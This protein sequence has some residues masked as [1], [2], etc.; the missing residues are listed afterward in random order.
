MYCDKQIYAHHVLSKSL[1]CF[2]HDLNLL[3][4][5][6]Y[7]ERGN[8]ASQYPQFD[9]DFVI[10]CPQR[11]VFAFNRMDGSLAWQ[12][13]FEKP[14]GSFCVKN[15]VVYCEQQAHVVLLDASNGKV[16]L[17]WDSEFLPYDPGQ[18]TIPRPTHI[19]V[20]PVENHSLFVAS[21]FE[22]AIKILSDKDMSCVQTIDLESLGYPYGAA[23]QPT[24][25]NDTI[26]L[27][28]GSAKSEF[29]GCIL[30]LYPT[31]SP[32]PTFET[33]PRLPTSFF[34]VPDL[35][36]DHHYNIFIKGRSLD[37]VQRY[38]GIALVELLYETA[39][40]PMLSDIK[41]GAFD[42]LHDGRIEVIIDPE[43][44]KDEID[45]VM[46]SLIDDVMKYVSLRSVVTAG[47]NLP[48]LISY[49]CVA[50]SEWPQE[51]ELLDLDKA[52]AEGKPLN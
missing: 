23:L 40:T 51:G 42:K 44:D 52:R 33:E 18:K 39:M 19:S 45:S 46:Q 20:Y 2:D 49:R 7:G 5:Y 4:Q 34:A 50:E 37:L 12:H 3:W 41:E 21:T 10:I 43:A 8:K 11:T 6:N 15:G 47:K 28:L 36:H 48:I 1:H 35:K 25:V 16:R 22:K 38:A 14:L 27:Q 30:M 9:G 17:D 24:I 32:D 13:E 31:Q 29:G 26:Y